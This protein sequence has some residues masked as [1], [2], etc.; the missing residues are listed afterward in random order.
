MK[1]GV[2]ASLKGKLNGSEM[3]KNYMRLPSKHQTPFSSAMLGAGDCQKEKNLNF[4]L[5][6]WL[7]LSG[8]RAL[9]SKM[10]EKITYVRHIPIWRELVNMNAQEILFAQYRKSARV[11]PSSNDDV[12]SFIFV[13]RLLDKSNAMHS[14]SCTHA[15]HTPGAYTPYLR[16]FPAQLCQR[17]I[18]VAV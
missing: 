4:A 2:A 16:L 6:T 14:Y 17:I 9:L 3:K 10:R 7:R 1:F 13:T 15:L 12:F 8:K 18:V 5:V 11:F